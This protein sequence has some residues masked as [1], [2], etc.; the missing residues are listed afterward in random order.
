LRQNDV[1]TAKQFSDMMGEE[2]KKETKKG[3]D[4]KEDEVDKKKPLYS[5]MDIRTLDDKKQLVIYQG[6]ARRPIEADK[7]MWFNTDSLKNR[8]LPEAAPLPEHLVP[9]HIQAMGYDTEKISEMQEKLKKK[10]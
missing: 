5:E 3:A 2:W 4:G 7:Q 1:L 10:L 9:Y 8:K 6:F